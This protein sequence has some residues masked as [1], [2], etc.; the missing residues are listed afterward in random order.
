MRSTLVSC[1]IGFSV[2]LLIGAGLMVKG[3]R[4]LT[5]TKQGFDP[6]NVLTFNMALSESKYRE[7][8]QL[9]NSY[10]ETLRRLS[11]L[12]E[13]QSV[14]VISELPALGDSRI[15]PVIIEG[16]AM[17][18]PDRPL[19]AEVRVTSEDYFSTL[20][21]PI[22]A[23]RA[24][25]SYDSADALPVGMISKTAA[26]RFWPGQNPVGRRLR[27]SVAG[28]NT[29][30][31]TIVGIVGDVNY[32]I[33]DSDVRP[34][35][36]V[37]Y[38]QQPIRA[39]NF[40]MRSGAPLDRTAEEVR[41]VVRNVDSSQRAYDLQ[42]LSRFF[43]DLSG[44]VGVVAALMAVIA[45]IA[46][47]LSAAGVYSVMAYSVIQRTQEIGIRMALG[48]QPKD[49]WK[50]LVGNAFRLVGIGLGFG[51]PAALG[52]SYVMASILSGVV[53]LDAITFVGLA[54]VLAAIAALASYIPARR[55]TTVDPLV[56][57]R[58]E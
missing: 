11:A 38:L 25:A 37:P 32:F 46:L 49:V 53:A 20:T 3:F 58:S 18:A 34:T 36:Y 22:L 43:A 19:L 4:Y 15:S 47:A 7:S 24:F 14:G 33:M 57:L 54:S 10:Q 17:A 40:V 52:L 30:W 23:G 9:T 5:V 6:T 45:M 35:V 21:I 2:V 8:Y 51:L 39:L 42:S 56:A 55:A 50:P 48:A 31:L 1:E 41:A 13:I 28:L 16:Q 27:L 26:Q 12:S 44:G 29:P